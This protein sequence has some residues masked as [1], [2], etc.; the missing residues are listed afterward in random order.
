MFV[1]D[2]F[3]VNDLVEVIPVGIPVTLEYS[4]AGRISKVYLGYENISREDISEVVMDTI[5]KNEKVPLSLDI[6]DITEIPGVLYTDKVVDC[7]GKLPRANQNELIDLFL[8]NPGIFTFYAGYAQNNSTFFGNPQ[9]MKIWLTSHGFNTLP[10]F[11]VT[12]TVDKSQMPKLINSSG[13]SFT[14]PLVMGYFIFRDSMKLSVF[15]GLSQITVEA[16]EKVMNQNG[17]MFANLEYGGTAIQVAYS[18]VVDHNIQPGCTVIFDN[19]GEIIYT[20]YID[21]MRLSKVEDTLICDW[22]HKPYKA[23]SSPICRCNDEHCLSRRFS[24]FSHFINVL[25]L[26]PL[27]YEDYKAHCLNGDIQAL[28]DV[29]DIDTYKNENVAVT[30]AQL[31]EAVLPNDSGVKAYIAHDFATRCQN[32]IEAIRYYID[33]PNKIYDELDFKDYPH[34]SFSRW[35]QDPVNHS[36][37]LSVLESP[38][39][40]VWRFEP[41]MT[42]ILKFA[43]MK[44]YLAGKFDLTDKKNIELTLNNYGGTVVKSFD[45]KVSLVITGKDMSKKEI[46]AVELA[47][48]LN[49]PVYKETVFFNNNGDLMDY[50]NTTFNNFFEVANWQTK[51]DS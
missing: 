26:A 8:E 21:E 33:N 15:T 24:Q 13:F 14:Y 34:L 48:K 27:S 29:L 39:I 44:I 7:C 47:T 16:V 17:V 3:K 46:E 51:I 31:F 22:C 9:S 38:H 11:L 43:G 40:N 45:E 50:I 42:K 5:I 12:N 36:D 20:T 1:K 25:G 37:V 4:T 23:S 30:F 2:T 49:V 28:A 41:I 10:A 6:K 32:R 18:E 35:L 19:D